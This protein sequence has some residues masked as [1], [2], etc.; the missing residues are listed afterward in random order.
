VIEIV[1]A[2]LRIALRQRST[3]LSLAL[4]AAAWP[5]AILF[6]PLAGSLSDGRATS[7]AKELA[8]ICVLASLVLAERKQT[9]HE[10]IGVRLSKIQRLFAGL[11]SRALLG[12]CAGCLALLPATFMGGR[13]GP[14]SYLQL[15][16]ISAHLAA[17]Y[18]F[19]QTI[20]FRAS[21]RSVLVLFLAL[22]LPASIQGETGAMRVFQSLLDPRVLHFTGTSICI[23]SAVQLTSIV[24]LFLLS[25]I[26]GFGRSR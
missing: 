18:L 15:A 19:L 8:F 25:S 9:E 12:I 16:L 4:S 2:Q 17:I 26:V 7:L 21:T 6:S 23:T 14:E 10:W 1:I 22:A 24:T 3:W 20:S 11:S 5:L 13:L